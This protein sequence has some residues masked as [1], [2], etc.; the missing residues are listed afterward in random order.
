MI[1]FL[2]KSIW[3]NWLSLLL[4]ILAYKTIYWYL[5]LVVDYY[6]FHSLLFFLSYS[7]LF[8]DLTGEWWNKSFY[9]PYS[10]CLLFIYCLWKRKIG[11][12][13]IHCFG[14]AIISFDRNSHLF[15]D[16]YATTHI[17]FGSKICSSAYTMFLMLGVLKWIT[18]CGHCINMIS[19]TNPVR[20]A[21]GQR[22]LHLIVYIYR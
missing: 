6:Y 13:F 7:R 8:W 14:S 1:F 19:M 2:Y 18:L 3:I 10:I 20:P 9:I 22:T 21:E 16:L 11:R 12:N 17:G 4:A 15:L 5:N